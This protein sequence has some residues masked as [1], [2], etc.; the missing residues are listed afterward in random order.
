MFEVTPENEIAWEYQYDGEEQGN[1]ARAQK[2]HPNYFNTQPPFE[3]GDVNM[4]N[5]IN[6]I[7]IVSMVNHILDFNQLENQSFNLG[8]INNDGEINVV[9]IIQVVNFI[10]EHE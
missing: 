1:I 6:V 8:D 9:D 3:L 10:L 5:A 4:D 2:Y 7:D